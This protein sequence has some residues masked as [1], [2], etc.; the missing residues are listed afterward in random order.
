MKKRKLESILK[1]E[2]LEQRTNLHSTKL[3]GNGKK[4]EQ[5]T[6]KE[7]VFKTYPFNE[8]HHELDHQLS[9][10]ILYPYVGKINYM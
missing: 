2:K 4:Q 7:S 9:A 1:L 6:S 10:I 3:S 8:G 5:K